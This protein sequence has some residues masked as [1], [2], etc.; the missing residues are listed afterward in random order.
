MK[1]LFLSTLRCIYYRRCDQDRRKS[2]LLYG[3]SG[4]Q[5]V[6]PVQERGG[7]GQK[8][9]CIAGACTHKSGVSLPL[10]G[11]GGVGPH[12]LETLFELN[13]VILRPSLGDMAALATQPWYGQ[14]YRQFGQLWYVRVWL[15]VLA[16]AVWR[17]YTPASLSRQL[18]RCQP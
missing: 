15:K 9:S 11:V 6:C 4:L 3:Q 10:V 18:V 13:T 17:Y 5:P 14:W 7:A 1:T 2:E 12:Q 8:G 16:N